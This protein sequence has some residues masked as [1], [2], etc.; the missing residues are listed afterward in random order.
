MADVGVALVLL[1]AFNLVAAQGSKE[2]VRERLSEEKRIL[3]LAGVHPVTYWIT[4]LIWDFLVSET[5]TT[6]RE[7]RVGISSLLL[8]PGVRMLHRFGR[9]RLRDLRPVRVRRQG[10]FA[11]H[12]STVVPVRVSFSRIEPVP[13]RFSFI[14]IDRT[15]IFKVGGD[16]VLPFGREDVRRLEHVEHGPVLR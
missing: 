3:L 16:T 10:Q 15:K 2:L 4:A 1:I 12:L 5:A 8:L 13:P 7:S 9:V 11:R 6:R 14:L